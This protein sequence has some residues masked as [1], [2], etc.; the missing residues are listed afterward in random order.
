MQQQ[1]GPGIGPI[2][3]NSSAAP[4]AISLTHLPSLNIPGSQ[5]RMPPPNI[6]VPQIRQLEVWN[7]FHL[8]GLSY[9][10]L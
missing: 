9:K 5:Q 1:V 8:L 4:S 7:S 3:N 2:V 10:I 6:T